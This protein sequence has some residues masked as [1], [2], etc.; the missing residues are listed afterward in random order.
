MPKP[1]DL[2]DSQA[3]VNAVV[4]LIEYVAHHKNLPVRLVVIDTLSRAMAGGNEN[5]PEDMTALISNCDRI[6]DT[7]GA[8]VCIIHHSGKDE[9]RGARGHSSLRAAT[10]TEIEIRRDPALTRS[11]ARVAKQRDLEADQPFDFTLKPIALGTNRRGKDVT[12]CV[13]LD[14]G[15]TVVIAR[16]ETTLSDK[17]MQ[18]LQCLMETM[19]A[20]GVEEIDRN[21]GVVVSVVSVDDWKVRLQATETVSR[22]NADAARVQF[23]RIRKALERKGKIAFYGDRVC[24]TETSET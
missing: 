18:A 6:R 17:E 3:D 19:D 22:N 21:N 14:A 1:V 23:N 13:V 8:H 7:T 10:D 5:S 4:Q 11:T 9:A 15:E 24:L 20:R 2:L 12:S 16:D